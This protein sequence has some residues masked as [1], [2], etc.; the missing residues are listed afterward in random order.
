MARS[1]HHPARPVSAGDAEQPADT[2]VLSEHGGQYPH[3]LARRG[4]EPGGGTN[5]GIVTYAPGATMGPRLQLEYELVLVHRGGVAVMVDGISRTIPAGHVGLMLPGRS[6]RYRFTSDRPTCHSWVALHP[7]L[8]DAPQR[9]AL[10]QAPPCLPL[11]AA[12][13][14]C[15]ELVLA[16]VPVETALQVPLLAAVARLALLFY[17]AEAASEPPAHHVLH[18]SLRRARNLAREQ[19]AA[20]LRVAELAREVGVSPEYLAR[21]CRRELGISPKQLLQAEQIRLGSQLLERTGLSVA[22]VAQRAGFASAQHFARRL[23]EA[24]GVSPL[25]LRQRSWTAQGQ[26]DEPARGDLP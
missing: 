15:G 10:D 19:A 5:G 8:L 18:P 9:T 25:A 23:R 24:M 17:L 3:Y 14:Q 7:A 16:I 22:E 11:S 13:V 2:V 4:A 1:L 21:L 20:G 6:E 26:V 12:M